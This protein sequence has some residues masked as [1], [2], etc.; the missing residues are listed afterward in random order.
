LSGCFNECRS[1][2][3]TLDPV[4]FVPNIFG[5][6]KMTNL[7]TVI[8]L[9]GQC[10]APGSIQKGESRARTRSP[11]KARSKSALVIGWPM[12]SRHAFCGSHRVV[13]RVRGFLTGLPRLPRKGWEPP[14]G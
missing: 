7:F 2:S 11:L 1:I 4:V 9:T 5:E 13:G 8:G 12:R 14:V 6:H 10:P 3:G